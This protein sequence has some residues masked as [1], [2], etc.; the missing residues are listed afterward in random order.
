MNPA[1]AEAPFDA[2]KAKQLQ[3]EWAAYLNKP[4]DRVVDLGNGVTMK[5]TLIP[6]GTFQMGSPE[7]EA[8]HYEYEGPQHRVKITDPFYM[9]VYPVTKAQF[10]AFVKDAGYQTD[11]EQAHDT[12]T[13]LKPV[14]LAWSADYTQTDDDPVVEVS[15]N[16]AVKFCDWLAAKG[17]GRCELPTE[18]Q[19]EY[20]CRAG[21]QTAYFFGGDAGK[22][23]EY[24][25]YSDNSERH[26]HP[27][28]G[29][30]PNPWG[31]YDMSGDVWQWCQDYYGPYSA[32]EDINPIR[33]YKVSEDAR[34]C[35]GGSWFYYA[36]FCRAACRYRCA[37]G[38]RFYYVG[39]RVCFRLD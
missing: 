17:K 19:W 23:G 28:G 15:W 12:V 24:A 35:R 7:G 14:G 37:P 10:A 3:Q 1:Q 32:N 4:V 9:G 5:L 25:W 36:E 30:K 8:G 39:L 38:S 21:T 34:V 16:D 18:A 33:K 20:A 11:A 6:P 2:A 31:L 22:L 13:W 29:K 26:T 27:V